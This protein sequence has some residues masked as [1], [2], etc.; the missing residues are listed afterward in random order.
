MDHSEH[1]GL[2]PKGLSAG[3]LILMF[4]AGVAVCAVFFSAGFLVGYNERHSQAAPVTELVTQPSEIPPVI[5]QEPV[6]ASGQSSA[7]KT[8]DQ[9][10]ANSAVHPEPLRPQPLASA[11]RQDS[12]AKEKEKPASESTSS[13]TTTTTAKDPATKP[14]APVKPEAAAA[15]SPPGGDSN[16]PFNIQVAA[17]S[18]KQ[19]ADKIVT[20]LK[21]LDYQ[22]F[23]IS[24]E[25][26]RAEDHLYRVEVGPFATREVAERIRAKL[27]Q[28]GFKQPFIKH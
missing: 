17:S 2:E 28:D 18:T 13:S 6:T 5:S 9:P 1:D 21:T 19:D 23:V 12:P 24:P 10:P 8:G 25:Q 26:S 4:L 7:A 20:A 27:I 22:V 3:H 15:T 14:A 11:A 16:A